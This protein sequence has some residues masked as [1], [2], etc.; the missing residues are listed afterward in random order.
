MPGFFHVNRS[1]LFLI[2]IFLNGIAVFIGEFAGNDLYQVNKNTDAENADGENIKNT[3]SYFTRIET[4]C[5]DSAEEKA[6]KKGY[7]PIFSVCP[8]PL[9]P[10]GAT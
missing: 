8:L 10:T 3:R 5:T 2:F 1:S 7:K 9:A 4:V 6:E